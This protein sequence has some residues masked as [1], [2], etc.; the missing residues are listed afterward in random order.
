[1]EAA[2]PLDPNDARENDAIPLHE[3][4]PPYL[5]GSD[6]EPIVFGPP[7]HVA[8][9]P[10]PAE[11]YGLHGYHPVSGAV[12]DHRFQG[13]GWAVKHLQRGDRVRRS[14][15]NGKGMWLVLVNPEWS[16]ALGAHPRFDMPAEWKGNLPFIAMFT[17][18]KYLVP[19]LCSQTD[20][21]AIDWELAG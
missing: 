1:M 5:R 14:G 15:W 21:L 4:G 20:I 2:M 19:W 12:V 11:N 6:L 10:S 17:A 7:G 16:G 3:A 13:I 9:E 8:P 18:D